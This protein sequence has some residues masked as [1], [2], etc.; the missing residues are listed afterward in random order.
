MTEQEK[1]EKV[2][3][4]LLC[5]SANFINCVCGKEID[6]CPYCGMKK[7]IDNLMRDALALLKAQEART[8]TRGRWVR[9][10]SDGVVCCSKCG[11]PI[12]KTCVR[13]PDGENRYYYIATK[14]CPH[15]GAENERGD[16]DG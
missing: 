3:K 11:M 14:Y 9:A 2:I 1:R 4:G 16:C 8:E 13:L 6:E 7:C 5:C 10:M 12:N 15:C